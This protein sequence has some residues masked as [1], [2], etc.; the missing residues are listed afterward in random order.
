MVILYNLV[1]F[2]QATNPVTPICFLAFMKALV[3][4]LRFFLYK[5]FPRAACFLETTFP[6]LLVVNWDLVSPPMV[7]A[8]VPFMTCH[9]FPRTETFLAFLR[10]RTTRFLAV[11]LLLLLT[12]LRLADLLLAVLLLAAIL[13][14]VFVS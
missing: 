8:R 1:P 9:F 2:L 4:P 5:D 10:R 7:L 6:R 3:H 11:L 14:G 12:V 13:R